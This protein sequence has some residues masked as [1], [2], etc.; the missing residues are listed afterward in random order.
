M[1][2]KKCRA[3]KFFGEVL[4]IHKIKIKNNFVAML[5]KLLPTVRFIQYLF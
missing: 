4:L 3:D 1:V 2:A 5:L